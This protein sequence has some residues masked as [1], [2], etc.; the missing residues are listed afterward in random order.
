MGLRKTPSRAL[1]SFQNL[2]FGP[3]FFRMACHHQ[4]VFRTLCTFSNLYS[5]QRP[6]LKVANSFYPWICLEI[7]FWLLF[8]VCARVSIRYLQQCSGNISRGDDG[9]LKLPRD[10]TEILTDWFAISLYHNYAFT[11]H[12]SLHICWL[13]L[14]LIWSH[15]WCVSITTSAYWANA[16]CFKFPLKF[17]DVSTRAGR[18]S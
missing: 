16:E 6:T 3:R 7:K 10:I 12:P 11:L 15:F 8:K 4:L 1:V 18:S 17:A 2:N 5:V 14:S 9:D 13:Y